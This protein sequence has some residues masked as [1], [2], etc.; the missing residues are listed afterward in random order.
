[1]MEA[2]GYCV[3]DYLHKPI[4]LLR[5]EQAT[6]KAFSY[7][8]DNQK[9]YADIPAEIL[10]GALKMYLILSETEMRILKLISEENTTQEIAQLVFTSPRTVESHRLS[11][12]KKLQLSSKYRLVDIAKYLVEAPK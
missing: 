9:T 8:K 3:T 2:L 10:E 1:M 4:A 5:F 7:A 6:Q 12:R 11:I